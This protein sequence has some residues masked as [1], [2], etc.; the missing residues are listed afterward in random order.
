MKNRKILATADLHFERIEEEHITK[1]VDHIETQIQTFKP[2]VFLIAGDTT[3]DSNLRAETREYANLVQFITLISD[4]CK[5][6]NV[7]F[8]V[9]R[10]TPSHDGHVMKNIHKIID[11]FIYIDTMCNMT[12]RGI[13]FIFV[14]E[15]YVS[16]YE[17]F[18]KD[19]HSL[20]PADVL[21]FHGMV[22][23]AIPQ[24][25][26][27]DSKFNM[28][29]SIIITSKDF[30]DMVKYLCVGGHVHSYINSDNIHYTNRII[31]E[32]GH[33]HDKGYGL[34]LIELLDDTYNFTK[35]DNPHLIKHKYVK[36]DFTKESLDEIMDK[37]K[38]DSY[39]DVIFDIKKGFGDIPK[40]NFLAWKQAIPAIYVRKNKLKKKD[41]KELDVKQITLKSDDAI[42]LLKS[43]FK[44]RY[45]K[46][47]PDEILNK[48]VGD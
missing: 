8:V 48:I 12:I 6:N 30:K 29:R 25:E 36:I 46:D 44:E 13:D 4:I 26:Q 11:G 34:C 28:G 18:K 7:A 5:S 15:M 19:L 33:D 21:V 24:L 43:I 9:L 31:N 42:H 14:P 32:R 45:G 38:F 23:F 1:L 2:D 20:K 41:A 40:A 39:N 22:D 35:L 37:S 10:G 17:D 3:D 16:K 27:V 47:I